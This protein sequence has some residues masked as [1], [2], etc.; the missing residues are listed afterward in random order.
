MI[1]LSLRL[2]TIASFINFDS[3]VI[4]VG[5]DHGLLDVY[6]AL[7]KNCHCLATD[8][9]ENSLSK[10]LSNIEK[11]NL[12][13]FIDTKVSDGLENINYEIYDYV[14][15]SGMG[16]NSINK[17]LKNK[18]PKKLI[19]QS[20]NDIEKLKHNL[21]K[22]YKI[23]D[24]KIV[25]ENNIYY[26]ILYLEKGQKRYKYSDYIIGINKD[27]YEYIDYLYYKYK[28]IYDS[29][30][31]KYILKKFDLYKKINVLKKYKKSINLKKS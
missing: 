18:S 4:D 6:L 9:S 24:E 21:L 26:D 30:P 31:N 5:C 25:F 13:D 2:Q 10:A 23:V 28:K 27:N 22:K 20:N 7:N 19:V 15:I 16:T 8:I 17:I 14:V 12:K 11:F 29:M 3:K 1:K